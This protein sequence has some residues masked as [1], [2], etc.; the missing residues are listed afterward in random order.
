MEGRKRLFSDGSLTD[1]MDGTKNEIAK[2]QHSQAT[3]QEIY[4]LNL[5]ELKIQEGEVSSSPKNDSVIYRIPF[6]G[7]YYLF[8]L[9]PSRWTN[10]RPF[11]VVHEN[12]EII[13]EVPRGLAKEE[14]TRQID[15]IRDY[16]E[17]LRPECDEWNAGL[18]TLI[19]A[20]VAAKERQEQDEREE[21]ANLQDALRNYPDS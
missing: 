9:A 16:L 2:A 3:M 10:E 7:S 4:T 17:W 19:E 1:W 8:Y 18:P 5:P 21:L 13:I 6:D 12:G 15:L 20:A 11:A 14:F